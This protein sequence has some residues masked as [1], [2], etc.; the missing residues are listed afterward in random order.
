M[1][2][3]SNKKNI[4]KRPKSKGIAIRN[5]KLNNINN[6]NIFNNE[7]NISKK[8]LNKNK[9]S[10]QD[11]NKKFYLINKTFIKNFKNN[12]NYEYIQSHLNNIEGNNDDLT[13]DII[14]QLSINNYYID[15]IKMNKNIAI[16]HKN[17]YF[18]KN[19]NNKSFK[20]LIEYEIISDSLYSLLKKSTY[21]NC[22]LEEVDVY[23]INDNKILVKYNSYGIYSQIG[24]IDENNIFIPE[25][26][27]DF[28]YDIQ[29]YEKLSNFLNNNL[30]IFEKN[31]TNHYQIDNQISCYK[32]ID[33]IYVERKDF[34]VNILAIKRDKN[35]KN[36]IINSYCCINCNSEIEI[37]SINFSENN[38]NDIIKYKCSGACGMKSI[39]LH[40]YLNKMILN[41]YLYTSC[42]VCGSLNIDNIDLNEN[43]PNIFSFCF[44]CKKIF[45]NNNYCSFLHKL[46]CQN[47][48]SILTNTMKDI[49][50]KH[51]II[52]NDKLPFTWFCVKDNK[53]LCDT[54]Y[55]EEDKSHK[56][57]YKMEKVPIEINNIKEEE[58]IL[59]KIIEYLNEKH[60]K[61]INDKKSD[62]INKLKEKKEKLNLELKESKDKLNSQ[63]N[64][65]LSLNK[66][67]YNEN[68]NKNK[69]KYY[70]IMTEQIKQYSD[71]LRTIANKLYEDN[72]IN[73]NNDND[74]DNKHNI[75]NNF[76][77]EKEAL[78]YDNLPNILK[79]EKNY[80]TKKNSY[81]EL[82]NNNE[83]EINNKYDD[84]IVKQENETKSKIL[85]FEKECNERINDLITNLNDLQNNKIKY[86]IELAEIILNT[87][88]MCKS[89]YFYKI[90]LYNLM[91]Y[92]YNDKDIFEKVVL[93]EINNSENKDKLY[94][95]ILRKKNEF[96]NLNNNIFDSTKGA[97]ENIRESNFSYKIDKGNADKNDEIKYSL[98]N[99]QKNNLNCAPIIS[100][101][102]KIV[103]NNV[104][105]INHNIIINNENAKIKNLY[106]N[107][108]NNNNNKFYNIN[109]D[110]NNNINNNNN[111]Y[112]GNN[113]NNKKIDI[114]IINN[115]DNSLN[116]IDNNKI[117]NNYD[118]NY[119]SNNKIDI[120]HYNNNNYDYDYD[121]INNNKI[122]INDNN[123][124]INNIIKNTERDFD[125]ENKEN[126]KIKFQ[127][128]LEEDKNNSEKN[129][130]LVNM[131]NNKNDIIKQFRKMFN[132]LE[133]D[134]PNEKVLNAL[135]ENNNDFNLAFGSFFNT[136]K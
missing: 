127:N 118:D 60:K 71:K 9:K 98:I 85:K 27:L 87:Y 121:S 123:Y 36:N 64:Y 6:I 43:S 67:E 4:R 75:I 124:D 39:A 90:N 13:K 10:E 120:K 83:K 73:N 26:F 91:I 96:N 55:K 106:N 59:L 80:N 11:K 58:K 102:N 72:L 45:C 35:L 25:Y 126:T 95:L 88:K 20:F 34:N 74:M 103:N 49:C 14:F 86:Q 115:K 84:L 38:G 108:N 62:L 117:N 22:D 56:I 29:N 54:C 50:L 109:N 40:E 131:N 111:N 21:L 105:Q 3:L 18:S 94:E 53:N 110:N 15:Q 63:R 81:I 42:Y 99:D 78:E 133:K 1:S 66:N 23:K 68:I 5:N 57:I 76:R 82:Y 33:D 2:S 17:E 52:S 61:V 132:L 47:K 114:N 100:D 122:D 37:N 28:K 44:S 112:D 41:T 89:N 48:S 16:P 92:F 7:N 113:V 79:T 93:E 128:N 12:F 116:N 134:Y 136:I 107:N 130:L 129:D 31:N 97:P 101:K 32:I 125:I 119:I 19:I 46:K 69:E 70:N 104:N 77:K 135:K 65:K 51:S 30:V 8:I 24:Y